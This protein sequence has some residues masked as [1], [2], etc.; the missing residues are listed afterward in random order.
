[1]SNDGSRFPFA[2]HSVLA[3][4]A[5]EDQETRQLGWDA[6]I[7]AYWKPVYK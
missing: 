2:R 3:L 7:R 1:M 6:L 4:V 5:S